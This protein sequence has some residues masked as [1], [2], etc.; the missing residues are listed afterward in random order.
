MCEPVELVISD[1]LYDAGAPTRQVYFPVR[2]FISLIAVIDDRSALEVGMVG[3]EGMLGVHVA[4]GV[5]HAPL[6]SLVQ[7]S[8]DAWRMSA[9]KFRS[10]LSVNPGLQRSIG[11]YVSVLMA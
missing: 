7:G 10:D 11:R 8:G 4:F 9:A 3:P 2:G 5:D 6:R 1:A